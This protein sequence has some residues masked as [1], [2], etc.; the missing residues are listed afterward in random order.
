MDQA[1]A[2]A[3]ERTLRD[4]RRRLRGR[5]P[6]WTTTASTIGKRD[7][8][9][10]QGRSSRA[11]S[12]TVDLTEVAK[13]VRGFYNSGPTTG[14]RLRPGRVQMPDLA[15]RLSDQ[16]R[17]VPQSQVVLPPGSVVS[18]RTPGADAVVDDVSHDHGRHRSSRR[19]PRPFPIGSSPAITPISASRCSTA[20][21]RTAG[22]LF[23]HQFRAARRRL[24]RQA[25]RGRRI[26]HRLHQ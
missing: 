4:S 3:R 25:Q 21:I 14:H 9:P 16:R 11:T 26:G 12:M 10:R 15:D 23:H 17:H 5:D 19:W 6:S 2:A 22:K 1:E 7:S 24:G 20:S 13:Q 8:D 18:A